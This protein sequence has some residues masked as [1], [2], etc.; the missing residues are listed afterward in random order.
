MQAIR[1]CGLGEAGAASRR[2]L[3]A[4][5]VDLQLCRPLERELTATFGLQV[6]HGSSFHVGPFRAG[7]SGGSHWRNLSTAY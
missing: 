1:P 6:E 7:C 2:P 4:A 5:V 3:R